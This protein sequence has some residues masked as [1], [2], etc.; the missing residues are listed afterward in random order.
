MI[1]SLVERGRELNPEDRRNLR[2]RRAQRK[3]GSGVD[4]DFGD[5]ALAPT[6]QDDLMCEINGTR[7]SAELAPARLL[8]IHELLQEV[9]AFEHLDSD[10]LRSLEPHLR[11]VTVHPGEDVVRAGDS[12]HCVFVVVSGSVSLWTEG[13]RT[14]TAHQGAI[15]CENA[16]FLRAPGSQSPTSPERAGEQPVL[17][18]PTPPRACTHNPRCSHGTTACAA[19]SLPSRAGAACRQ[20]PLQQSCGLPR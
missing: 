8:E 7:Q 15:I 17:P 12:L 20:G 1:S 2:G 9:V 11:I 19:S 13:R 4:F 3:R 10:S 5:V 18:S 14:E 6:V 16:A